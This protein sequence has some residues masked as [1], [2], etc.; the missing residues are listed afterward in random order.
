MRAF[1]VNINSPLLFTTRQPPLIN[2]QKNDATLDDEHHGVD[3]VRVFSPRHD[4]D[5][6]KDISS[7]SRIARFVGISSRQWLH[8][9]DCECGDSG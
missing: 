5:A 1:F 9:S 4:K 3:V 8:E 2:P 7:Q 6:I